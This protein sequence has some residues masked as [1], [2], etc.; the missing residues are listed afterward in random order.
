MAPFQLRPYNCPKVEIPVIKRTPMTVSQTAA[1][2]NADIYSD[3][4]VTKWA[5]KAETG[6]F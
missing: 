1:A 3:N 4:S 2:T 5:K 6:T